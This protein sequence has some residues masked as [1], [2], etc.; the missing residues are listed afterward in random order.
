MEQTLL[1]SRRLDSID[2]TK[3]FAI[4][5]VLLIHCSANRFALFEIG[6]LPWLITTFWGTVSRWA[7]PAFLLCSGTLMN[8]PSRDLPLKKLFSKY[9]LRLALALSVWAGFYELLRIYISRGTAPLFTLLVQAVKNW[10]YG[11]TYYHLYYFYF[12]LALYFALPLTRL[13]ARHA[14]KEELRYILILWFSAGTLIPLC[15][16]LPILNQ[17]TSSLLRYSLAAIFLCPGLGLLGWYFRQ[18]PPKSWRSGAALFLT[19]FMIAFLGMW[20]RSRAAGALDS[21]FLDGF[22]PAA[23]LMAGGLFRFSQALTANRDIHR[24]VRLISKASFCIY[25]VH[26]FFQWLTRSP[27]FEALSPL[28]GT[29]LQ[30][31]VLFALSFLTYLILRKLPLVNQ[32]LI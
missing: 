14:S 20:L 7:V 30:A 12:A 9:I 22:N 23:L 18:H 25:L 29:P 21:L 6:S 15:R 24:M 3:A 16:Q 26:P 2:L 28:W 32:W 8:D 5:A 11:S 4:C 31:L 17:M 19:G 27:Y 13:I 10:C 1:S